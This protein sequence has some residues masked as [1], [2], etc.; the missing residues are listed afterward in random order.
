MG[1]LPN[2]ARYSIIIGAIFVFWV[3]YDTLF[4][5][6]QRHMWADPE[7]LNATGLYTIP[8]CYG[9]V[10]YFIVRHYGRVTNTEHR[11]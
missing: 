1:S 6:V 4:T 7:L 9:V 5:P 3:F 2:P 10:V 8:A 11:S